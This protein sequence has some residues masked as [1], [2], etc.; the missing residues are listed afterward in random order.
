MSWSDFESDSFVDV[1]DLHGETVTYTPLG[2]SD[3]SLTALF[4][5]TTGSGIDDDHGE[6]EERR[7]V[8]DLAVAQTVAA[9]GT[10]TARGE[11]WHIV[12]PYGRDAVVQSWRLK[13]LEKITSRNAKGRR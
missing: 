9:S 2:G 3:V 7:A 8:I 5:E 1:L 12:G 4:V 10:F 6:R 11:L 13:R